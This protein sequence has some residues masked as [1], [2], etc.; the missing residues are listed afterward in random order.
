MIVLGGG[1]LASVLIAG[2]AVD[3]IGLNLHP[4]LLGGGVPMFAPNGVRVALELI[5]ARPI[6]RGCVL[7]TYR[8]S[9]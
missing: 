1:E 9:R 8:V 2:G 5:E 6:D 4:I 7:L 3:E